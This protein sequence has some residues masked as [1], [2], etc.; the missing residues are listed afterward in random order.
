[1]AEGCDASYPLGM[2]FLPD[3]IPA[4]QCRFVKR[5]SPGMKA[6]FGFIA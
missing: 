4:I 2:Y 5:A 1:M 6:Q 3:K